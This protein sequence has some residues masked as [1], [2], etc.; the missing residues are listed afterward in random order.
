MPVLLAPGPHGVYE[1]LGQCCP[2]QK[3]LAHVAAE[4]CGQPETKHAVNVDYMLHF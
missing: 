2:V 1:C 3:P 4:R